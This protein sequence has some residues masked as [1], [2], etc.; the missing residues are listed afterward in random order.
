EIRAFVRAK[1]DGFMV[2]PLA[3]FKHIHINP[4]RLSVGFICPALRGR[5]ERAKTDKG[6]PG[7]YPFTKKPGADC[8]D[9][10]LQHLYCFIIALEEGWVNGVRIQGTRFHGCTRVL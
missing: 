4:K 7:I 6:R 5:R 1:D 2:A 9:E 10:S 3:E 8:P